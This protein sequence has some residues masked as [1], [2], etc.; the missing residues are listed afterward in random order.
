MWLKIH[1]NHWF[2]GIFPVKKDED[3]FDSDSVPKV[4]IKESLLLELPHGPM[5]K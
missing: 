3:L 4:K 2:V 1:E 5:F